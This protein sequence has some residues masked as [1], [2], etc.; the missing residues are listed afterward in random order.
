[1]N[2]WLFILTFYSYI[3]ISKLFMR[4]RSAYEYNYLLRQ[5]PHNQQTRDNQR[6]RTDESTGRHR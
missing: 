5:C 4:L 3:G 6:T 2:I 1:M